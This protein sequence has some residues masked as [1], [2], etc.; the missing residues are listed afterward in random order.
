[1]PHIVQGN[2]VCN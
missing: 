1:M 2:I